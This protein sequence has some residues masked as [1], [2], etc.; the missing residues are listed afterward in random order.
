MIASFGGKTQAICP[1]ER[2]LQYITTIFPQFF[3]RE[4]LYGTI[5]PPEINSSSL[6]FQ[7]SPELWCLEAVWGLWPNLIPNRCRSPTPTFENVSCFPRFQTFKSQLPP[8][9]THHPLR[10]RCIYSYIF[11]MYFDVT[12]GN[13][14]GRWN[15]YQKS[16]K[17]GRFVSQL[18]V[19]FGDTVLRWL[20]GQEGRQPPS[21]GIQHWSPYNGQVMSGIGV[22]ET[23]S[24][25]T[26]GHVKMS[27]SF[28]GVYIL[29]G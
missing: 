8:K 13:H 19:F 20:V 17:L 29:H 16:K 2:L 6:V 28:L 22:S 4:K 3:G 26:S 15:L 23:R 1:L 11:M 18:Y 7:L 14:P 12:G 10:E 5:I 21:P 9:K 24:G 25:Q 27:C